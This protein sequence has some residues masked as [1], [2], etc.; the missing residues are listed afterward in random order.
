MLVSVITIS[1]NGVPTGQ[2]LSLAEGLHVEKRF[3]HATFATVSLMKQLITGCRFR[4][5]YLVARSSAQC[6][7]YFARQTD[8][9]VIEYAKCKLGL[10]KYV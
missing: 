10:C 1:V 6:N 4:L 9:A 5:C 3:F 8:L 2:E 7:E